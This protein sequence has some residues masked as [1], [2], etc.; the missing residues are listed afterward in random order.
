MLVDGR[1]VDLLDV[2]A[3]EGWPHR[4]I[5]GA[6]GNGIVSQVATKII[7]AIVAADQQT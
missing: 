4:S 3:E 1:T 2:L 5:L 6:L 7:A